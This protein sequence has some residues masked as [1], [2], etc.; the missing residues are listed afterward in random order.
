M[1]SE[2]QA[3][4]KKAAAAK[5]AQKKSPKSI[6]ARMRSSRFNADDL[7]AGGVDTQMNPMMIKNGAVNVGTRKA[8]KAIAPEL[9]SLIEGLVA[10]S[11]QPPIEIWRVFQSAYVQL[12][13]ASA[14]IAKD[15]AEAKEKA[16]RI[17]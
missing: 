8:G 3:S 13:T 15:L 5:R 7:T 2:S 11:E 9:E 1:V 14:E 4:M 17:T 6:E 16:H 10:H 12:Q